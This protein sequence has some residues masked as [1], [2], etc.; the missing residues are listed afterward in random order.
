MGFEYACDVYGNKFLKFYNRKVIFQK[1]SLSVCEISLDD[2]TSV[3][4]F[5]SSKTYHLASF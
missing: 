2:L 4:L 3:L 5:H 1:T